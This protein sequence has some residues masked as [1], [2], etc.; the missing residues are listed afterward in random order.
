MWSL[1]TQPVT[2]YTNVLQTGDTVVIILST[3]AMNLAVGDSLH[4]L[5]IMNGGMPIEIGTGN[6]RVF[7]QY[8]YPYPLTRVWVTHEYGYRF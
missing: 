4:T 8:P 6:P 2:Q 5:G 3:E 1:Q 7:F